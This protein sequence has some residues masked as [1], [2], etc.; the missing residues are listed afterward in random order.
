MLSSVTSALKPLLH[1]INA[2]VA[3]ASR[4]LSKPSAA[5]TLL[6]KRYERT[7]APIVMVMWLL[8]EIYLLYHLIVNCIVTYILSSPGTIS[9]LKF[10]VS[11]VLYVVGITG[12][13]VMYLIAHALVMTIAMLHAASL[14]QQETINNDKN[15]DNNNQTRRPSKEKQH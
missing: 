4:K 6:I 1:S 7:A 5:Q 15:D 14:K 2:K 9:L 3:S 12:S 10:T 11:V 13:F 8:V